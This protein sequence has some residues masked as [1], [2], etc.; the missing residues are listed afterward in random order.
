MYIIA[1]MRAIRKP[2]AVLILVSYLFSSSLLAF[3]H[4]DGHAIRLSSRPFVAQHD[5]GANEIHLSVDGK[6]H[7]LACSSF[8]NRL[9]VTGASSP[10]AFDPFTTVVFFVLTSDHS[11]QS[12]IFHS[13]TRGPPIL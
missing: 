6:T 13:G 4:H 2:Y 12:G 7:C 1:T 3:A 8:Y 10:P 9:Y 11:L 5:C